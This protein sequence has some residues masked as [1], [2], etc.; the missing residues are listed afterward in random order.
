MRILS[1]SLLEG[2]YVLGLLVAPLI[3]LLRHSVWR[4][5]KLP[6]GSNPHIIPPTP[7]AAK[8]NNSN[9]RRFFPVPWIH[10]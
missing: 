10:H 8:G 1:G 9:D 7:V 2:C 3:A 5:V 4:F 6:G